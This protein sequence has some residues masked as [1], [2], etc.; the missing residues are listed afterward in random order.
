MCFYTRGAY[1][2]LPGE[3]CLQVLL[4]ELVQGRCNTRAVNNGNGRYLLVLFSEKEQARKGAMIFVTVTTH[5]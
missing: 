4:S 5:I 1:V 3:F 2:H